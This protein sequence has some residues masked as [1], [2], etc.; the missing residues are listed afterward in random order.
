VEYLVSFSYDE[1]EYQFTTDCNYSEL[2]EYAEVGPSEL[3]DEAGVDYP[4]D[5]DYALFE[6]PYSQVV[7]E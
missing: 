4:D 1:T 5:F 2:W 3:F 7:S 6:G